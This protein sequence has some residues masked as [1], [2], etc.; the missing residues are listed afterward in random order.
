MVS[1]KQRDPLLA[2]VENS[3]L[4]LGSSSANEGLIYFIQE[5]LGF[6]KVVKAIPS[7]GTPNCRYNV[8]DLPT[9]NDRPIQREFSSSKKTDTF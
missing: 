3:I 8:Q 5:Q 9:L 2:G 4:A 1:L 6:G 7:S